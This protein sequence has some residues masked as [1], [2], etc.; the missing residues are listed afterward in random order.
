MGKC[1]R[2]WNTTAQPAQLMLG[3]TLFPARHEVY[4]EI[5]ENLVPIWKQARN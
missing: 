5:T 1:M 3:M 4:E 2:E